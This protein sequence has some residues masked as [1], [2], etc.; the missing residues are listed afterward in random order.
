MAE[1]V[2]LTGGP[3]P[4]T[5][6]CELCA[7]NAPTLGWVS[8]RFSRVLNIN[9]GTRESIPTNLESKIKENAYSNLHHIKQGANGFIPRVNRAL[10]APL[11][12]FVLGGISHVEERDSS[13]NFQNTGQV[14]CHPYYN[15][16]S[17]PPTTSGYYSEP[18]WAA[19]ASQRFGNNTDP[20]K[21]YTPVNTM[22]AMFNSSDIPIIPT[23]ANINSAGLRTGPFS[24]APILATYNIWDITNIPQEYKSKFIY[25]RNMDKAFLPPQPTM[26][27]LPTIQ[28]DAGPEGSSVIV[29]SPRNHAV[30]KRMFPISWDL[31]Y[32][33]NNQQ[34]KLYY[35]SIALPGN[36]P[37]SRTH[38]PRNI[39]AQGKKPNS[40][41]QMHFKVPEIPQ[42]TTAGGALGQSKAFIMFGDPID[43]ETWIPIGSS[44]TEPNSKIGDRS[45][46]KSSLTF[47]TSFVLELNLNSHPTLWV[48]NPLKT[49]DEATDADGEEQKKKNKEMNK[50]VE[51]PL[52]G[53]P[54]LQTSEFSIYV[55]FAGGNMYIGFDDS[56]ETW[57][58]VAPQPVYK[59]DSYDV[60]QLV[61]PKLNPDAEISVVVWYA[62]LSFSYGPIAFTHFNLK[63]I[64]SP[65]D[66]PGENDDIAK[67]Q[68]YKFK[69]HRS[70]SFKAGADKDKDSVDIMKIESHFH[71]ERFPENYSMDDLDASPS[72]LIDWRNPSPSLFRFLSTKEGTRKD[73]ASKE[74][75]SYLD[76]KLIWEGTIEGPI[77]SH[78]NNNFPPK[79]G[80]WDA[81]DIPLDPS[82]FTPVEDMG[83]TS[84]R[85]N[86]ILKLPWG[87]ISSYITDAKINVTTDNSNSSF[88]ASNATITLENLD[89]TP[90]GRMLLYLINNNVLAISI[91]AG[92]PKTDVQQS[93]SSTEGAS[94]SSPGFFTG[95]G[96]K[97]TPLD[98]TEDNMPVYFQG[99]IT[100]LTTTRGVGG[101][102]AVLEAQDILSHLTHEIR[103]P[104]YYAFTGMK[105]HRIIASVMKMI[106][107]GRVYSTP[108]V[109][110]KVAAS[111]KRGWDEAVS[112][113]LGYSPIEGSTAKS[114]V[115]GSPSDEVGKLL[116]NIL[117]LIIGKNVLPAMFW[118]N[119]YSLVRL[120]WRLN[121]S[122]VDKLY[123]LGTKSTEKNAW[124]LPNTIE[125]DNETQVDHWHGVLQG[126]W[127]MK[128]KTTNLVAAYNIFGTNHYEEKIQVYKPI[129]G[130]YSAEA[131]KD[132][133][134]FN[135]GDTLPTNYVGFR[136]IY[137]EDLD[138]KLPDK[139]SI[140][141]YAE[142]IAEYATKTYEDISF[143][144]SV[145]RPL[146][147][148]GTFQIS[149]FWGDAS[150]KDA[151]GG[152]STNAYMYKKIGYRMNKN[153]NMII[154]SVT[155]EVFPDILS[156]KFKPEGSMI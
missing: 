22:T 32:Q 18:A 52:T 50:W 153:D 2:K 61:Y 58:V 115:V 134:D 124:F 88:I 91:S 118:D 71:A 80:S 56:M 99:V 138:K 6:K 42:T 101:T 144:C 70:F 27:D 7:L 54:N 90:E 155:G 136:K 125:S 105:Y 13:G 8:G 5:I 73:A 34:P 40:G 75:V 131:L 3:K 130:S 156:G 53:G 108:R 55:H 150:K 113:R 47:S 84:E 38:P 45:A 39:M 44:S 106:G 139:R 152:A 107:L 48:Y 57:Q 128:S 77:L 65:S 24:E 95:G 79:K 59:K 104:D 142:A 103:F 141:L 140:E 60:E 120:E 9:Q 14:N 41:F 74:E 62:T 76:G 109:K 117:T 129:S 81:L 63:G 19:G 28:Q 23:R 98:Y 122:Y 67:P 49:E 111:Q 33:M 127:E 51:F 46:E 69:P 1:S 97:N 31:A 82:R 78:I 100:S 102:K 29:T 93:E 149:T 16:V 114:A 119:L 132:L 110:E 36:P 89:N 10:G 146:R 112:L 26:V 12:T 94:P 133:M 25:Y 15:L 68:Y 66:V 151:E 21:D 85:D 154:A 137:L 83:N 148:Y 37:L 143:T 126:E 43:V 72:Y 121:P 87:D 147:A 20:V 92:Y 123:F 145:T 135:F 86:I 96:E 11:L 64:K 30:V 35:P 17:A 4:L 116:K